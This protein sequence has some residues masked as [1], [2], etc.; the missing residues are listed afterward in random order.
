MMIPPAEAPSG[1]TKRPAPWQ[2]SI[3]TG[4]IF[5][6]VVVAVLVSVAFI[7]STAWITEHRARTQVMGRLEELV[8]SAEKVAGI[9]CFTND[10]TLARETARALVLSSDVYRVV[11]YSGTRELVR[12]TREGVQAPPPESMLSGHI[13]RVLLSPFIPPQQVGELQVD[14]NFQRI[15]TTANE[16]IRFVSILLSLLTG[17]TIAAVAAVVSLLVVR[18][19][20]SMCDRLHVMDAQLGERLPAPR[21]H[22]YSELGRLVEDING[23]AG[24][25]DGAL[26]QEHTL[27][28]QREV[29]ELKYRAIFENVEAGIF[30]VDTE[31]RL[32]SF[33]AAFERQMSLP[34]E[35]ASHRLITGLPWRDRVGLEN[36]LFRCIAGNT[37]QAADYEF[38]PGTGPA[39]W[40]HLILRP[41]GGGQAQGMANDV[42]DQRLSEV[43]ARQALLTDELTGMANRAGL[44]AALH[45][46]EGNL[47][48]G[49]PMA[50]IL[51]DLDG[52]RSINNALGLPVGDD[53]LRASAR[54]VRKCL[55]PGNLV[56]R[57]G[58]DEFAVWLSGDRNSAVSLGNALVR[59]LDFR[60]EVDDSP[61]RI[62]ASAGIALS[63]DDGADTPTLLRH[64]Q[65]ALDEARTEG[66]RRL[67]CF[68][69][70]ML[71]SAESRRRLEADIQMA[72]GRDEL[73]LYLQ[74]I[75]DI[76]QR[77][78]VGAEAL[79]RWHHPKLGLVSPELFIPVAE[80]SG[81]IKDI[82]IWV[83]EA[84]CQQLARWREEGEDWYLSINVSGRQVPEGLP[85]DRLMDT[86][87]RYGV[88]P[89]RLALEITEGVFINDEPQARN[90]LSS[91]R[92]EG[93]RIYL[94]DFGTGYSS[95]S[96]LKRFPVDV[97]KVDK[98]FVRDMGEVDSDRKLVQAVIAMAHSLN[99]EVVAEGVETQKQFELLAELGCGY[100][101]GY[102]FSGP[103]SAETF[104]DLARRLGSQLADSI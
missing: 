17:A 57:L 99:M 85:V 66:G 76:G 6:V 38:C 81:C 42:T 45:A 103:V 1:P 92:Q 11:I 36:M 64:A 71:E 70:A 29:D 69:P 18:P 50:L 93:L 15:R 96:Y 37:P 34:P 63:P 90:W 32:V 5:A 91:V 43:A 3:L 9:A 48:S 33:N 74:P 65:L 97:V 77:R 87:C 31:F 68:E 80:S 102:Y 88:S 73:R 84:A 22:E 55:A 49:R 12:M 23:L 26:R 35:P 21:G 98:S 25:M 51:V 89:H 8:Q 56:A 44:E 7:V 61:L 78:L 41:V 13:S 72:I 60:F 30:I 2:S 52:F 53:I 82:G 46:A 86:L 4:S 104:G 75:V 20:K 59:A 39:R 40:F 16:E 67:R 58:G 79:L 10:V 47:R 28:L 14:A 62:G 100:V 54:R 83:M 19:V 94:D 27:R 101:Q 95:L 24:R